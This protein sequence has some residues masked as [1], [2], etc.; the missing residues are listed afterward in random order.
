MA[1]QKIPV[2]SV[3]TNKEFR[4]ELDGIF[5]LLSFRFNS[6]ATIWMMNVSD[7][8]SNIIVSGIALL[9]GVDLLGRFQDSRLPA[10][11]LFLNNF[12]EENVEATRDN[13]GEDVLL[14]YNQVT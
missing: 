2:D 8:N 6:R 4:T 14:L 13:L 7:E 1:I 5:Y 10:G 3:R 12:S 9:L 11:S